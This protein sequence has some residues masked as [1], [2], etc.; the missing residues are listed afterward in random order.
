[1]APSLSAS[2]VDPSSIIS[3][4]N[5]GCFFR[6]C[7][8]AGAIGDIEGVDRRALFGPDA[9]KRDGHIFFA[10]G[11]K[12]FVE[13]SEPVRGLDL[14]EGVGGMRFVFDGDACRK[15]EAVPAVPGDP[16]AGNFPKR[17]RIEKRGG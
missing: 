9:R 5:F 17:G 6:Y 10:E 11:G 14:D 16:V 13:K 12:Q 8:A 4:A 1:M 7:S 15:I 2:S 3:I